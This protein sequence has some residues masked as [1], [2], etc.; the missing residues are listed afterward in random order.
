MSYTYT[1]VTTVSALSS[2]LHTADMIKSPNVSLLYDRHNIPLKYTAN[3]LLLLSLT[4]PEIKQKHSLF[5]S[6]SY[7]THCRCAILSQPILRSVSIYGPWN[8][9][10]EF[11]T[12]SF[13]FLIFLFGNSF[14]KTSIF[15][16]AYSC[17]LHNS[18][19]VK[20]HIVD[21]MIIFNGNIIN[22]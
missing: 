2:T 16:A 3:V 22:R 5:S 15:H 21:S 19:S 8:N 18:R 13:L 6:T 10:L 20:E 11:S 9:D 14:K 12:C 7:Y 17:W 4:S 1:H